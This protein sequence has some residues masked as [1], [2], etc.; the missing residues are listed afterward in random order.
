MKVIDVQNLTKEFKGK[1][2]VKDVS[3]SLEEGKCTALLGPNGAG[4]TTTLHMIAG[5]IKQSKGT[6]HSPL[7]KSGDDIRGV[8][9]FLPQYPAFYEWMTGEEYLTFAG[10][11]VNI[12]A[13]TIK[14]RVEELIELVGLQ[15][16]YKRKIGGYSGGMRQRLGIAQALIHQPKLVLLD[17]P[18]S[19]LDPFGRREVLELM[20]RLKRETTILFSTHILNDAEEVCD[21]VL[22]MND[23]R[24]IE[25]G[26]LEEVKERYTDNV[27]RLSFSK[28]PKDFLLQL[29]G[30]KWIGS[31]DIDDN[32][33]FIAVSEMEKVREQIFQL[34][35]NESW[36]L[37][38]FEVNQLTLEEV[39]TKVVKG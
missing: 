28:I 12:D 11:L 5:L 6:I 23:G 10:Q 24:L 4:K 31:V 37:E 1:V 21:S 27:I 18:V 3:F 22:F 29:E 32:N 9:G 36:P 34:A 15:D 2:A 39:F 14:V 17:E 38:K 8:I 26:G 13:S 35:A 20:R 33:A 25:G 30:M 7:K 16:G 19:A